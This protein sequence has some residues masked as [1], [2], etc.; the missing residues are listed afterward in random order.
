MGLDIESIFMSQ[1]NLRR[2]H[3]IE[4]MMKTLAE[5]GTLPKIHLIYCEDQCIQ[6]EDGHHRL[7]AIWS[8]GRT[9]LVIFLWIGSKLEKHEYVL[10]M[11]NQRRP[12]FGNI[13][14]LKE[15]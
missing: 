6:V 3:Q 10:I 8:F 2:N 9:T 12:R 15:K 7:F 13:H 1:K 5:G 14:R 11:G 4:S